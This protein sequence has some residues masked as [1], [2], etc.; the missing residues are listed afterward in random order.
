MRMRDGGGER[1]TWWR[2]V[3]IGEKRVFKRRDVKDVSRKP[4]LL[5][6][7]LLLLRRRYK[8]AVDADEGRR[9]R[10]DN[11]VEIRKNRREESLQKKRREGLQSQ[12]MPASL[13]SSAAEKKL[14]HLPSMVAGV[15]SEDGSLQLEATT[16][17][18][19]LLSVGLTSLSMRDKKKK[20]AQYMGVIMDL[21]GRK[22]SR[23]DDRNGGGVSGEVEDKKAC[24]D[25]KTTKTPLWRGGPAGPKSMC[26][27]CGIR[28][29]KK[30]TM[31]RLEKGPE[32]KREK[33][34]SSN[35]TSGSGLISESLRMSLMVLG[36]EMMLQRP[37]VVKKK[38]EPKEK[39]VERGRTGCLFSDGSVMRFSLFA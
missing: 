5:L 24:T 36:E 31:M 34:T 4:C 17:F 32:K 18:R 14:E 1:I 15:W 26:N 20:L 11:M 37:P 19:K 13:H 27:A 28:Y 10:E 29:R 9:R 22:S 16:Q 7:T 12:A 35:T 25:C 6:F 8:V 30:R 21:K 3:R 38:K 2:S 39:E 23:E 33:T